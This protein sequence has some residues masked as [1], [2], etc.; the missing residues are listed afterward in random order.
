VCSAD[1]YLTILTTTQEN[2]LA[3][4]L[5][6]N[7]NGSA[8]TFISNLFTPFFNTYGC[9]LLDNLNKQIRN[10][11]CCELKGGTWVNINEKNVCVLTK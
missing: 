5:G 8:Q 9:L 2:N 11:A 1:E 3:I 10:K 4:N 6:W 7:G